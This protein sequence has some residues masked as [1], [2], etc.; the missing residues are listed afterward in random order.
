[1]QDKKC[2][3]GLALIYVPSW[4]LLVIVFASTL[5][6]LLY[7]VV[8]YF[9]FLFGLSTFRLLL[10]SILLLLDDESPTLANLGIDHGFISK[11]IHLHWYETF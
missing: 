4:I 2:K 9:F 7:R 5:S 3:V 6:F 10:I 1:M 8:S 11:R